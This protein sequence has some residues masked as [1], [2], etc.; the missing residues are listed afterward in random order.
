MSIPPEGSIYERFRLLDTNR[1]SKL[2]RARDCSMLTIPSVLPPEEWTEQD[3]LVQPSSSMPARGVTNLASRM[4]SALIPLN[5][6]PFFQFEVKTGE[7]LDPKVGAF[8]DVI[9]NQVYTKIIGGNFRETVFTALQHLIITGDVMVVMED[10]FDFRIIRQDH[11]VIRRDI[12][13]NPVEIIHLEFVADDSNEPALDQY[14][15]SNVYGR[16]GYKTQFVRLTYNETDNNWNVRREDTNGTVLDDGTYTVLPYSC[17][18]WTAIPGENYGRSHCEEIYGDIQTL[19][20]YTQAMLEGMAASSAFWIGVNPAGVTNIEDVAGRDNG[21]YISAR[22]EDIFT[23]SPSDTLNPQIQSVSAA[24]ETMRREVSTSFLMSAGAIPS[25]DRVTA[26]AVR[27]IGSELETVLGGAFSSIA[28][29]MMQPIVERAVFLMIDQRLIDPRLAQQF[30]DEGVLSVEIITGLQALSRDSDLTKLIQMGE[31]VRNLP[32]ESLATFKWDAYTTALITALGLDP[33]NWV[34]SE[35]EVQ[36][37]QQAA[38]AQQMAMQSEQQAAQMGMQAATGL[39]E[40]AIGGMMS[41][42]TA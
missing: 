27:M 40:Q 1:T 19:E 13:G 21:S 37:E 20:S 35:Q 34:K 24:V 6:L 36:Q 38:M 11:Y 22:R 16:K 7:E 42:G 26:T 31:M 18:R 14:D 23:I 15:S 3:A 41:P 28:R 29:D 10:D 30:S 4:L 8:L 9:A 33:A 5:D 2:D 32:P 39:A 17:L 25:G 12:V